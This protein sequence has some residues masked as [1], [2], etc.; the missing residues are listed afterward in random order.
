[1]IKKKG[2]LA[3]AVA[4]ALVVSLSVLAVVVSA[5]PKAEASLTITASDGSVSSYTGSFDEIAAKVN[6]TDGAAYQIT[7]LTD[8]TAGV[9]ISVSG[10]VYH[11]RAGRNLSGSQCKV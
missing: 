7:L 3:I 5:E 6:S 2:L 11:Q 10:T 8:A 1:M 9:G 4:V